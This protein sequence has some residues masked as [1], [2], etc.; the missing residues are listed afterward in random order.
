MSH[1]RRSQRV[2]FD[3]GAGFTLSG[4]IDQPQETPK[5]Y[6]IF[7]HCFTCTKDLKLIVRISRA[8]AGLGFGVLR[9][10][11]TGLGHS[12][13]DFSQTNF[14]TNRQDLRAAAS[15]VDQH[16]A[17]PSFLI[18]HSFGGAVSLSIAEEL[19]SIRS[20]VSMAAPSNTFHL[21]SLLERKNPQIMLD[22]R[23][24]V[25][26]G[27]TRHIID[28]QMLENFRSVQLNVLVG[29]LNKPALLMH[30]PDD[31]TLGFEHVLQLY[32]MLS[33]RGNE[34]LISCP[35]SLICLDGAD[36]LFT[37]KSSDLEFISRVIAAW[38]DR[39][40]SS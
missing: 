6:A 31:E 8:L 9:Y 35:T 28:K 13:G 5:A 3:G 39:Q 33:I 30:S 38:F 14:D 37:N 7:T 29:Q 18:G 26:I 23:G 2:T 25:Q 16:Y 17:P 34:Q 24:E 27:K 1:L 40:L 4:I 10:D 11:L 20:V 21:A 32:Q 15:F 36:H 12:S 22:G 19:P